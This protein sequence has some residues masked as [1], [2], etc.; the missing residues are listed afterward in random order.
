MI[1]IKRI[2]EME[3]KGKKLEI[4][5]EEIFPY[6]SQ[7]KSF[8][9]RLKKLSFDISQETLNDIKVM[10]Y[11]GFLIHAHSQNYFTI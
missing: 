9:L 1:K 3:L 8:Q 6:I 7:S 10:F 4:D 11:Y 5:L 2:I